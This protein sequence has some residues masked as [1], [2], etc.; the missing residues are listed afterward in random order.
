M[1][2]QPGARKDSSYTVIS[3][4]PSVN[5]TQVGNAVVPVPYP[6]TIDLS[7]NANFSTNVNFNNN[8]VLRFNSDTSK[9]TGDEAGKLGGVKSGTTSAKAEP[10][11][12]SGSVKINGQWL[13]RCQDMFWMNQQNTMGRLICA[14]PPPQGAIQDEG[15]ID[16]PDLDDAE[17][18]WFEQAWD[19]ATEL[20]EDA[21]QAIK[22]R[23]QDAQA[24]NE[25]Y[26]LVTRLEGSVQGVFGVI[27]IA[28]GV[29]GV[30]APEPLT[31]AGGVLLVANGVDNTQSGFRQVWS[32][33]TTQSVVEAGLQKG[34][35]LVGLDPALTQL[36]VAGAGML[37]NPSKILTKGDDAIEAVADMSEVQRKAT[38][39]KP[40]Q[41]DKQDGNDG[42]KVKGKTQNLR[43]GNC[44]E[45]LVNTKLKEE[46]W[47]ALPGSELLT[48]KSGHGLDHVMIQDGKMLIAETK[49][50]G[51]KLS[52]LQKKGGGKYLEEQLFALEKGLKGKGRYKNLKGNTEAKKAVRAMRKFIKDDKIESRHY[53]LKL[54]EDKTKEYHPLN[55]KKRCKSKGNI[56][57]K[58]WVAK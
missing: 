38:N 51:S 4:V 39:S 16:L 40:S 2:K 47:N 20:V 8:A 1:A 3:M 32:G 37:S 29:V 15:K 7:N 24:L 12:K 46:G 26:A 53:Q 44:A 52:K 31:T 48:N 25:K 13:I 28:G 10:K 33:K 58:P 6:V 14:P 54:A 50:N 30:I 41:S 57:H 27:E 11:D 9:V 5:K 56:I 49:A 22:G 43:K 21:E 17:K 19:N 36:A 55:D 23:L 18:N 45:H 42:G 35:N 34:A